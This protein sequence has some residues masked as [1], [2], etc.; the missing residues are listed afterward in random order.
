MISRY[1][2]LDWIGMPSGTRRSSSSISV[3]G[4]AGG[5]PAPSRDRR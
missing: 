4:C 1:W 5:H 3:A 2:F